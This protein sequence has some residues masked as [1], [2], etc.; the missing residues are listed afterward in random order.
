MEPMHARGFLTLLLND[1][2]RIKLWAMEDRLPPGRYLQAFE[3]C[4]HFHLK[5]KSVDEMQVNRMDNVLHEWLAS[6]D[7]DN[8][9]SNSTIQ[10]KIRTW[11]RYVISRQD[12]LGKPIT[13]LA[14]AW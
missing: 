1:G 7:N 3:I 14:E 5:P 6:H 9:D 13:E 11:D 10:Q 12:V 2:Q 4:K 8:K